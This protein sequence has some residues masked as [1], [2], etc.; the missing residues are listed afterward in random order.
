MLTVDYGPLALR[1]IVVN[2]GAA[3]L[4]MRMARRHLDSGNVHILAGAPE[5]NRTV[6]TAHP[7]AEDSERF[8][9]AIHGL[10]YV[11]SL[12]SED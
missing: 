2:G 6:F 8:N 3:Y 10:R 11:A 12:E 1:H 5:F 4:P 7:E 9:T